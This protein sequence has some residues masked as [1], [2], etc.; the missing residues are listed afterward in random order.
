M[1]HH[2]THDLCQ[3]LLASLHVQLQVLMIAHAARTNSAHKACCPEGESRARLG[4]RLD[5]ASI[6]AYGQSTQL[7]RS[8]RLEDNIQNLDCSACASLTTGLLLVNGTLLLAF[9]FGAF[10]D[11]QLGIWN[12]SCCVL[13]CCYQLAT[14]SGSGLLRCFC[15]KA[16]SHYQQEDR[17]EQN[18]SKATAAA[19]AA[20]ASRGRFEDCC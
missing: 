5:A 9:C 12:L 18:L 3:T 19:A 7:L 1:G 4:S 15:C 10:T 6:V 17:L 8:C 20:A 14:A 11:W 16:Y 2:K 13:L